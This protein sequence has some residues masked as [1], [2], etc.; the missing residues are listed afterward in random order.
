MIVQVR[1]NGILAQ[2]I[3]TSNLHVQVADVATVADVL[4]QLNEQYPNSAKK[5][6]QTIPFVAG[7]HLSADAP[8]STGQKLS[9][10]MPAAG[11]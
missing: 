8:I 4:A 6:T 9:L 7:R 5:I 1:L 2:E 11:G 3:G 10:L